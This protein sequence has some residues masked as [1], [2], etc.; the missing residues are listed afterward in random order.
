MT[1]V[2]QIYEC[3]I[4]GNKVMIMEAGDGKL[5]CCGSDMTHVS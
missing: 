5:V 4:C 2:G 3:E 1:G